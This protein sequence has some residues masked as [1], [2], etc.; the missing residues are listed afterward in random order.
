MTEP[1][2]RPPQRIAGAIG[3]FVIVLVALQIFLLSVG[4][5]ALL[6]GNAATAWVAAASSV[7]LFAG[8]LAFY[9]YVRL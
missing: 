7:V 2:R 3:V 4:L 9:R 6:D 5:E 8:A 1:T